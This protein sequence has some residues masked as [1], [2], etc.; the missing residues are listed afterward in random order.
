MID[1]ESYD[2]LSKQVGPLE[3]RTNVDVY[4][5]VTGRQIT[6]IDLI[7]G[8]ILWE[9][10]TAINAINRLTGVDM[11]PAWIAKDV[12]RKFQLYLRAR[13]LLPA[14]YRDA[15]IGWRFLRPGVDPTFRAAVEGEASRLRIANPG[16]TLFVQW[17]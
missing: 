17:R 8:M 9:D 3:G 12:T 10:K 13:L 4:D 5:P 1:R 14:H 2:Y 6:D 11:T 15:A 16:V 7:E